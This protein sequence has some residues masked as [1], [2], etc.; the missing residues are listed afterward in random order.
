MNATN[1]QT[2]YSP[3]L[4]TDS[5]SR[6]KV[7]AN[8]DTHYN[9]SNGNLT[10]VNIHPLAAINQSKIAGLQ[11][12][13]AFINTPAPL[14]VVVKQAAEAGVTNDAGEEPL[15]AEVVPGGMLGTNNFLH[16]EVDVFIIS[17]L[18]G[19]TVSV[20]LY[21]G[22]VLFLTA[23]IANASGGTVANVGARIDFRI[24]GRNSTVS[25]SAVSQ[26]VPCFFGF[27]LRRNSQLVQLHGQPHKHR[28]KFGSQ[29]AFAS[30]R[31]VDRSRPGQFNI[32]SGVRYVQGGLKRI[33]DKG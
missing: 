1:Q 14:S 29:S 25:Q 26:R 11:A 21:F 23:P 2:I 17:I 31:V 18:S 8:D 4:H 7:N 33:R 28:G 32:R 27:I 20:K 30:K 6:R 10:D 12:D 13:L 19:A 16:G 15:Y 24:H 9:L 5:Y 22:G 3:S